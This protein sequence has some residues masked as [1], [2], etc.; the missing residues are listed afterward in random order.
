MNRKTSENLKLDFRYIWSR[1]KT[2]YAFSVYIFTQKETNS[3][4]I[5]FFC[6]HECLYFLRYWKFENN[7]DR[8]LLLLLFWH[9]PACSLSTQR[10][11]AWDAPACF[12][13]RGFGPSG[14]WS[15]WWWKF[16]R[17]DIV[18]L[19]PKKLLCYG[20]ANWFQKY[21]LKTWIEPVKI[22]VVRKSHIVL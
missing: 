18:S 20:W 10:S 14:G 8:L 3:K 12:W 9:V 6:F 5:F 22:A 16:F 15:K 19:M 11:C 13:T 1:R 4:C 21:F 17:E 7:I 2:V